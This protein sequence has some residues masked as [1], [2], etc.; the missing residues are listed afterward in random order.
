MKRFGN[1]L[2]SLAAPFLILVAVL[3]FFQ[4]EGSDRW[5]SFPAL[6][7][8][9]GLIISGAWERRTRRKKL[10]LAIRNRNQGAN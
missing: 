3:G 9:I 5:Q 2:L 4:R 7:A 8:G 6:L 10:L 1:R